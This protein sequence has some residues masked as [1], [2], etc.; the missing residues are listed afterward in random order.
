MVFYHKGCFPII[1][2]IIISIDIGVHNL[3][4]CWCEIGEDWDPLNIIVKDVGRRDISIHSHLSV[5]PRECKL[6]HD[7]NMVDYVLHFK[8]DYGWMFDQ[9]DLVLIERQP[10]GGFINIQDLLTYFWR[11]KV[12]L[13]NPISVHTHFGMRMYDYDERKVK[14]MEIASKFIGHMKSFKTNVRKHDMA[15]AMLSILWLVG[16]KRQD[17]LD[18]KRRREAYERRKLLKLDCIEDLEQFRMPSK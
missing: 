4:W 9:S 15:D 6:H 10:P 5:C 16:G 13:I 12:Q 7:N 1:I 18:E 8:Q 14:S 3:G 11:D 17:Y 2:M